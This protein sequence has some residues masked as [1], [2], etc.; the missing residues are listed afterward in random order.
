MLKTSVLRKLA[1]FSLTLGLCTNTQLLASQLDND[2]YVGAEACS[3]CHQ[4]EHQQWQQSDHHKAM[5]VATVDSVLGDFSNVTVRYHNIDSRFYLDKKHY[6]V[7]TLDETGTTNTFEVKYTFG[8]EP[9]QQYLIETNDGHIQALN[10]AWDSRSKEQGGQQWIHLQ[11]D[12]NI[13]PE[14]P[15]FW[16]RYFQNWNN[17]CA[18]CHSTNVTKNYDAEAHSYNTT[19]SEINV[20]CEACHGSGKKH[21]ELA[22]KNKLTGN[23]SGFSS[24]A[25]PALNWQFKL[26]ESIASPQGKKNVDQINM[27]GD[28]HSLRTPLAETIEG[29]DFHDA[30]RLQLLNEG[31]YFHDGQIRE[32]AFVM[33]SFLQSKMHGKGVTCS[34][35]HNPHSGKVL[36][37]GN[38]LCAQCHLPQVFDTPKHH[39]HPK[40]STGAACVN[41]HMPERT[42][43]QVDDRRDHSFTTP[44]PD[45][46]R[47]LGVPNACTNCHMGQAGKDD[48]WASEQL[49]T[50]GIEPNNDHWA[51]LSQRV[52]AGDVLVTQAITDL[53]DEG[54]LPDIVRASLLQG[55]AAFPSNASVKTALQSLQD[56]NPMVRRA[57]V[58]AM[59]ALPPEARWKFL[60]PHLNDKSRSVRFQLAETL[61]DTYPQLRPDQQAALA[62]VLEEYLASLK[63]SADSPATQAS[64]ALLELQFGN[65]KA[66]ENA[67]LQ[68]LRIE[69][70][71]VTVLLNMADFYRSTA[72]DAEAETLLKRALSVA[73]D[74][75]AVQHSY[76]LLLIRKGDPSGALPHLKLAIE[77]A[78][79]Q[80]RYAYVYAVA[81]DNQGQTKEAAKVLVKAI[82]RWPNQYDLLMTLVLYLEKS[83][84]TYSIKKYVSQLMM[85]APNEP[86]VKQLKER[87]IR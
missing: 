61:A 7:D 56:E 42:Y 16:T 17:R 65:I 58:S 62:P 76:G 15:F 33:G 10:I 79:A 66:A 57:A 31:S 44:R 19:W 39:H 71:H 50:W 38:G 14:H 83:G 54:S 26:G 72:R 60:S 74:S 69:P 85:I 41:C 78:D 27:C 25:S 5:Q 40:A 36:I 22:K 46:S 32:E 21:L 30:N 12:E 6:Y 11:P 20:S 18:S 63:V 84:N 2:A 37:E 47:T 70:N 81:L 43:M 28:C 53:V 4:E 87:Y 82:K 55:L 67:Y 1:I 24:P 73:P 64:I 23:N 9:L 49:S 59:Q 52:R 35:C 48:V 13:N 45:L 34:N 75:G 29:K 77:Q 8:F 51:T 3:S 68:A 80:A 86:S